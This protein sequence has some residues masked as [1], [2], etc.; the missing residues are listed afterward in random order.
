MVAVCSV[1]QK[2]HNPPVSSETEAS[3][4]RL[5]CL[6]SANAF[7]YGHYW[8]GFLLDKR[9]LLDCPPQTLAHLYQLGVNVGDIDLV[10]LSHEHNDH[11]LGLD[12]FLLEAMG[13]ETESDEPKFAIVCPP[14]MPRRLR[15]VVGSSSRLPSTDDRRITWFEQPGGTQVA[16]AGVTV[17][18]V[19]M[20]HTPG[21]T[22]LGFRI[23]SNDRIIAYS[24]DTRM[25]EAL[26]TLARDADMLIIE[27]GGQRSSFHMEWDDIFSLRGILP[28][29]TKMLVTHYDHQT[30]PNVSDIDGLILAEDFAG[31]R[32]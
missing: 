29:S 7:S 26:H 30:A 9:V 11:I 17:E 8:S 15:E 12:F 2:P 28:A 21:I 10:L 14:G 4:L 31:Y 3:F 5:D 1:C 6:G 19:E 20:E 16:W 24:G 32:V 23:K 25:C 22:A 18:C 27:C 13:S